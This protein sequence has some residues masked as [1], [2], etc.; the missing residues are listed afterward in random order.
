MPHWASGALSKKIE[1]DCCLCLSLNLFVL[2]SFKSL[3]HEMDFE[4]DFWTWF[5]QATKAVKIKFEIDKKSSSKINL[6]NTDFK[7]SSTDC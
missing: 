3:F 2:D 4:L 5:L 7:K 6:E 1:V